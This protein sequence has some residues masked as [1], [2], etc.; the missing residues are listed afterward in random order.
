MVH[1]FKIHICVMHYGWAFALIGILS[2]CA[3]MPTAGM[4]GADTRQQLG[5]PALIMQTAEGARWFYP[6]GPLGT[7]TRAV[8]INR[9]GLVTGVRNVLIDDVIQTITAGLTADD[10]LL[11]IGPPHQ[12]IRFDNLRATAWDYRYQDTWGYLVDLSVMIDDTN[13][14]TGRVAQ[15]LEIEGGSK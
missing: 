10:V 3:T 11:K 5:E 9:A 8:D 14:V 15:R 13:R 12:R 6:S 4:L 2:A 7:S 1:I